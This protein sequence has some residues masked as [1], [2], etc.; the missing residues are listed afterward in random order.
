V[1]TVA[2]ANAQPAMIGQPISAS[3]AK[4]ERRAKIRHQRLEA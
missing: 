2:H 4:R 3:A 1:I